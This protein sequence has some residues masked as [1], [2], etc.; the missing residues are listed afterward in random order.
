MTYVG[1]EDPDQPA[2]GFFFYYL[3]LFAI[4]GQIEVSCKTAR[5]SCDRHCSYTTQGPF[6][7]VTHN[8][9][10]LTL[11]MLGKFSVDDMLK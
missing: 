4:S 9:V 5:M 6:S 11:R 3:R 1:L 7:Y 2:Q 8:L 10:S